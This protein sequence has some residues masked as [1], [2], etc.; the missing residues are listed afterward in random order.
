MSEINGGYRMY[1]I[2]KTED[3]PDAKGL[4]FL[5]HSKLKI[6]LLILRHIQSN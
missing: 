5:M 4:A 3:N 2:D 6:V 1:E